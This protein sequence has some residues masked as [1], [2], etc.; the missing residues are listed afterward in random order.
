MWLTVFIAVWQFNHFSPLTSLLSLLLVHH[1]DHIVL[2]IL[3][4]PLCHFFHQMI[5]CCFWRT[6]FF[7]TPYEQIH[8]VFYVGIHQNVLRKGSQKEKCILLVR[9]KNSCGWWNFI[10]R[11]SGF[12]FTFLECKMHLT[13]RDFVEKKVVVDE[14]LFQ[15]V[16]V[17]LCEM[18]LN[19]KDFVEKKR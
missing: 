9:I 10:S 11:C 16:Q 8:V 17:S 12:F 7:S 6:L 4:H 14:T 5:Q 15:N 1:H 19:G 3:R 13:G 2:F 18:H